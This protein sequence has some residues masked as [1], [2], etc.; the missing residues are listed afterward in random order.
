MKKRLIL[1]LTAI[2]LSGLILSAAV[3]TVFVVYSYDKDYAWNSA[4]A[5]AVQ[6]TLESA[7]CETK[8]Y[9]MDTRLRNDEEWKVKS[10]QIALE[11]MK[12]YEPDVIIAC[13]DNAQQ[14]FVSLI[15]K[16]N[17]TPVIF[18]GVNNAPSLYGYPNEKTT[19]VLERPFP[20]Q[21]LNMCKEIDP[22][23]KTVAFLGDD[24]SSTD[25]F[26]EFLKNQ[27]LGDFQNVGFFKYD[28]F[29]KLLEDIKIIEKFANVL[30]FIR[31]TEL[32]D[33]KGN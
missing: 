30:Y 29:D 19:G 7:E 23:I 3:P 16:E 9:Y 15:A 2:L 26:I 22:E 14:Y 20:L 13:D 11:Q 27:D 10:G 17:N 4:L 8:I 33:H 21:S 25:G 28:R 24:T 6:N 1:I 18:C 31:T 5:N 12:T 32:K